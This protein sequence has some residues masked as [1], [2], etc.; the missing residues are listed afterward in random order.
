MHSISSEPH[1]VT[2]EPMCN[3]PIDPVHNL[4][5]NSTTRH[6]DILLWFQFLTLTDQENT[7]RY[8]NNRK[9]FQKCFSLL[10]SLA[11]AMK[12]TF[13]TGLRIHHCAGYVAYS[14]PA[15]E[16]KYTDP[17]F[18]QQTRIL[19]VMTVWQFIQKTMHSLALFHYPSAIRK[20][21]CRDAPYSTFERAEPSSKE[22]RKACN[23][24]M[25]VLFN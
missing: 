10:R 6:S 1:N 25:F 11:F 21:H 13:K 17:I 24:K 3:P 22:R 23:V 2:H 15:Y 7:A 20:W 4:L 9:M 18:M 16:L 5:Q 8:T 14:Y 12:D 19:A